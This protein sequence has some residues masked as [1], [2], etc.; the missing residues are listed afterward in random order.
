M[1]TTIEAAGSGNG[2]PIADMDVSAD[3][4]IARLKAACSE[5]ELM[6]FA[7]W[8]NESYR[9][10]GHR[11]LGRRGWFWN[12][13]RIPARLRGSRV[14]APPPHCTHCG[15]TIVETVDMFGTF[16]RCVNCA[17]EAR[18]DHRPYEPG[19]ADHSR[20]ETPDNKQK[21]A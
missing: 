13:P 15:G 6:R 3:E 19:K 10:V 12:C 9:A 5:D 21:T 14:M 18:L 2:E 11:R 1:P 17:R 16:R 20:T 4:A 7:S 8:W